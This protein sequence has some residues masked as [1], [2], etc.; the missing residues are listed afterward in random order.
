[1]QR[2]R[3][4]LG[5]LQNMD[6]FPFWHKFK[7]GF[8]LASYFMGF[9]SGIVSTILYIIT[10]VPLFIASIQ[11]LIDKLEYN[12]L[13]WIQYIISSFFPTVFPEITNQI[14]SINGNNIYNPVDLGSLSLLLL[15]PYIMWLLSY[16]IGLTLN[17]RYNNFTLLKKITF[18]S[19]ALILSLILGL[20]ETFPA[21]IAILEYQLRKRIKSM[22]GIPNYDFYV[23]NK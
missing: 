11:I 18:H 17:L 12:P 2:R 19:Y 21:F 9:V 20:I 7:I 6:K 4:I 5:T 3:W 16:Q 23:V 1:M 22:E 14:N 8:K 15:F 10:V 13:T